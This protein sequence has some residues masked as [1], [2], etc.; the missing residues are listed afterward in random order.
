MRSHKPV[1]LG[2][3]FSDRKGHLLCLFAGLI[4]PLGFAPFNLWP[5]LLLSG[6]I[7]LFSLENIS[8]KTATFRGWL[9]GVGFFGTGVSWVYVS[10]HQHGA[11]PPWLAGSLTLIFAAGL[12]LFF[13]L[14]IAAYQYITLKFV[15]QRQWMVLITFPAVWVIA[16]WFRSW[17]LTGFPWIYLGYGPID[18]WL[19][20]WAPITGIYGLSF[21]MALATSAIYLQLKGPSKTLRTVALICLILP[22]LLG[23][24]LNQKSWTSPKSDGN[25]SI[26]MIQGNTPQN[27]KWKPS[28]RAK[29]LQSYVTPTLTLLDKD[30]II[31]PETAIPQL[32]DSA[33]P[34]LRP[35]EELLKESNT[36][37]I[38]GVPSRQ[39]TKDRTRYFNSVVGLA[40]ASGIYHKQ[41]LVPFGEYVPLENTL[42]GLIAFFD[43]PM[44]SFS[45]GPERQSPITLENGQ[46]LSPF[47]C[48]EIVYPDLVSESAQNADYILTVSNDSWFGD[49]FAP[50]QHLQMA[51]MRAIENGRYLLRAT[52]NGISAIV[53]PNGQVI[54]Q[55]KQFVATVLTSEVRAMEGMTLFSRFGSIPILSICII[56]LAGLIFQRRMTTQT[57]DQTST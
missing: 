33:H 2:T 48:Y 52:N 57:A 55:T 31:W 54:N 32:F 14:H 42:R 5:V 45:L 53:A 21:F 46:S 11:A 13:A 3:A 10:I 7:L 44:S 35:L 37:L 20:G 38:T 56:L 8:T 29:I 30:L 39:R 19:A 40:T 26:A 49:S 15:H 28:Q 43:L 41:R 51:R 4:A 27:L 24:G 12:A 36:G 16:E 6:I 47:I 1:A 9:Y 22:F 23:W 50:H 18:T 25:L 17:F 34:V